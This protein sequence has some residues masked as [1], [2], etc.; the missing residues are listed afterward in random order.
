MG[1]YHLRELAIIC[2]YNNE[3][4]Y[5]KF[6]ENIK[7][8][9]GDV[10][11]IGIDNTTNQFCSCSSAYNYAMSMVKTEF[12]LFLHQDI[13]FIEPNTITKIMHYLKQISNYDILGLVGTKVGSKFVSTNIYVENLNQ[14]GGKIRVHGLQE[15]D[16]LDEC[17]FGGKSICF[18]QYPFDEEL[19]NNWHLYAVERALAAK[20]RGDKVFVCDVPVLHL[21]KGNVD[22]NFDKCFLGVCRKYRGTFREIHTPC[23]IS[24]TNEFSL[25]S[26]SIKSKI[27]RRIRK[28]L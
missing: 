24:K 2:C 6:L 19:C 3:K 1:G 10:E 28:K 21:S 9:Q 27:K 23:A 14:Y 16:T 26:W 25:L 18:K 12:V 4:L 13:V 8:Q 7:L 22:A 5:K 11:V 15:C 20:E 17:I